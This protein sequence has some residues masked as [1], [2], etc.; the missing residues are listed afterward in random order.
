MRTGFRVELIGS[1]EPPLDGVPGM[2]EGLGLDVVADVAGSEV[3]DP[4][5]VRVAS[6]HNLEDIHDLRSIREQT[7]R[8][9]G[10]TLAVLSTSTPD[11]MSLA[12]AIDCDDAIAMPLGDDTLGHRI[13]RLRQLALCRLE[14]TLRSAILEQ[15]GKRPGSNGRCLQPQKLDVLIVGPPARAKGRVVEHVQPAQVVF[16]DTANVALA[17]IERDRFDIVIVHEN[18]LPQLDDWSGLGLPAHAQRVLMRDHGELSGCGLP[19]VEWFGDSLALSMS[20]D[21]L[22]AR[23]RVARQLAAVGRHLTE[24]PEWLV[25]PLAVDAPSGLFGSTFLAAYKQALAASGMGGY[26]CIT[27]APASFPGLVAERGFFGTAAWLRHTAM[28]IGRQVRPYDLVS[29]HADGR[30]EVVLRGCTPDELPS[31][32]QR[33][34]DGCEGDMRVVAVDDAASEDGFVDMVL[35]APACDWAKMR[36]QAGY[37]PG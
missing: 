20:N 36:R 12:A 26:G 14:W 21:E 24:P 15:L 27:L 29:H 9:A 10:A 25:P 37:R 18:I 32:G 33:L 8:D 28:R 16:A 34:A 1:F 6:M 7:C 17:H 22:R 5:C 4:A 35:S 23:L 2:L 31:V 13:D 30:F 3:R 19:G 11:F